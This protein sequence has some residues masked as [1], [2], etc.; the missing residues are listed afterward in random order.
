MD[1][2]EDEVSNNS[3][4]L[5]CVFIAVAELLGSNDRRRHIE[6]QTDGMDL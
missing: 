2:T 4:I 5:A 6:T 1:H 3:S